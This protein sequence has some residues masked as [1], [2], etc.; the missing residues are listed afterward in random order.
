[1]IDDRTFFR[2]GLAR[3]LRVFAVLGG[4][5]FTAIML[6]GAM[7]TLTHQHLDGAQSFGGF[8]GSLVLVAGVVYG[9]KSVWLRAG[10]IK[11]MEEPN[12]TR[13]GIDF[14]RIHFELLALMAFSVLVSMAVCFII[15]GAGVF[16]TILV[17]FKSAPNESVD[18]FSSLLKLGEGAV[19]ARILGLFL[20]PVALLVGFFVLF[21]AYFLVDTVRALHRQPMLAAVVVLGGLAVITYVFQRLPAALM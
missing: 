1:M 4:I 9:A 11:S 8:M 5:I 6:M 16:E 10:H 17:T 14:L 7:F 2:E 18:T 19:G 13:L 12:I 20:L 15:S 3:I 21:F